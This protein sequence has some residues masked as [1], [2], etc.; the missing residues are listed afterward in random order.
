MP[1]PDDLMLT[2]ALV[3]IGGLAGVVLTLM[4]KS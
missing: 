2:T 3:L 4:W 1:I